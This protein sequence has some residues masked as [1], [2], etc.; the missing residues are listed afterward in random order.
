MNIAALL[1][2]MLLKTIVKIA[3]TSQSKEIALQIIEDLTTTNNSKTNI[4][5]TVNIAVIF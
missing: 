2:T 5:S 3:N 1:K 4:D